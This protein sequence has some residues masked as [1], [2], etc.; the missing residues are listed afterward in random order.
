[1]KL[2]GKDECSKV[3]HLLGNILCWTGCMSWNYSHI[4]VVGASEYDVVHVID[5]VS[6]RQK[7][8]P[9]G[10]H[11]YTGSVSTAVGTEGNNNA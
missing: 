8:F 5:L 6:G 10:R 2:R 11:L 1:M 4:R 3:T 7:V 9:N